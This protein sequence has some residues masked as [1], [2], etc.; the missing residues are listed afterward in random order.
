MYLM[1]YLSLT[2]QFAAIRIAKQEGCTSL[3][4]APAEK[5]ASRLMQQR[6][7]LLISG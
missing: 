7:A 1:L 4:G 6:C 5:M 3:G 2:P